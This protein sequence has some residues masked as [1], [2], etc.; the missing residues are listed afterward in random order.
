M[1]I[2]LMCATLFATGIAGVLSAQDGVYTDPTEAD[3]DF[4][5]QGEYV[6]SG[7]V[8]GQ[9]FD[10]GIQVIALGDHKFQGVIYL[11]GLPGAGWNG[12]EP[13]KADGQLDGGKVVFS[14]DD[15]TGTL[16]N[17]KIT[18]RSPE[19]ERFA[20][21]ERVERQSPTLGAKPPEN[22]KVLFDGSSVE[23]WKN[24]KLSDDG[25]LMQG[26]TSKQMFKDHRLHIEF[27]L[28][29][30]PKSRGQGRGN[31]GLYVQGRYECQMLDSFGLSG[32]QNECG[33]LYSVK[34]PDLNMCL[35][36]LSWQT[37]D[38][39]FTAAKYDESGKLKKNPRVTIRHN[40]VVIHDDVELPGE[41]NTTAAPIGPGPEPG[42]VYL[43][44]HGN[45]VRY[46]NIWVVEKN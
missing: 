22:A 24:G 38:V 1:K 12:G 11:G 8:D 18:I 31:S 32:E 16:E 30:Q 36:P 15:G 10:M 34:K 37:Y 19:G 39:D 25:Y 42:P 46:R 4:K 6:A 20:V 7:E 35:P 21:A 40:G 5:R 3:D 26:T 27:R 2:A 14:N 44:N 29:Y 41:R 28:P 23:G 13:T 33:G 17:G 45:P 43:Q 9:K